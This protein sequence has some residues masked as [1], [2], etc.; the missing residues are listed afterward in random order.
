MPDHVKGNSW[1]VARLQAGAGA[2]R[3]VSASGVAQTVPPCGVCGSCP[4]PPKNRRTSP[5]AGPRDSA[6]NANYF[7]TVTVIVLDLTE[8]F[9]NFFG[10][11]PVREVGSG[12]I[13]HMLYMPGRA[14]LK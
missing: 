5:I 10:A 8:P 14:K 6:G 3:L 9:Q 4:G 1:R 7:V 13:T 11:F 12:R 2:C